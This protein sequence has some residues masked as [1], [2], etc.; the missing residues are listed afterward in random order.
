VV[1]VGSDGYASRQVFEVV[2]QVLS[3]T[4]YALTMLDGVVEALEGVVCTID[5]PY[6]TVG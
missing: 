6:A 1:E 3:A 5:E 2:V 4:A